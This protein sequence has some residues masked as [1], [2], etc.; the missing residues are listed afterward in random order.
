MS[1]K[2]RMQ[3]D[4]SVSEQRQYFRIRYPAVF[5][6]QVLHQ[7]ERY[8]VLDLSEYGVKFCRP[9]SHH[10]KPG[11]RLNLEI[12]FHDDDFLSCVGKVVRVAEDS[13]AVNLMVPVPLHKIR[14][15]HIF[16]IGQGVD[17]R[18]R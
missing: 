3:P 2:N 13:V 12:R 18:S 16:L 11:Q 4:T 1:V 14:S 10:F 15:Q 7:D 17:A 8:E 9:G 5:R 6:P